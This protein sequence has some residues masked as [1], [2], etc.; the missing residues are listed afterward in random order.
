MTPIPDATPSGSKAGSPATP[1]RVESGRAAPAP[2]A[3]W[4][5]ILVAALGLGILVTLA[6]TLDE[7]YEAVQKR[8]GLSLVDQPL[9]DWSVAHRTPALDTV[10]TVF[11]DVGGPVVLPIIVT[12]LTVLLAWRWRSWTPIAL[13]LVATAGSL[14]L[15]EAGKDIANRVRPPHELAVPPYENSPSFPSGHTLN[16]TVVA[17]VLAYLVVRRVDT[18]LGRTL[19]VVALAMYAA[20]MG[21][22]RVFLGHHWFTDVV[23]GWVAGAAWALVIVL[24]HRLLVLLQRRRHA[25]H[26]REAEPEVV[27]R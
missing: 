5:S 18:R 10:V 8:D 7:T 27:R 12:L 22:S 16:S 25:R 14:A 15:T 19:V 24:A 1:G 26:E 21:L 20:L 3:G 6:A 4:V 2:L 17:L 9:L 11:T 13:M 23:A